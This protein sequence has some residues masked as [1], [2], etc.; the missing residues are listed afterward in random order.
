MFQ[1]LIT[2]VPCLTISL[3]IE[4][5]ILRIIVMFIGLQLQGTACSGENCNRLYLK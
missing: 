2:L 4:I 5:T 3:K 1:H